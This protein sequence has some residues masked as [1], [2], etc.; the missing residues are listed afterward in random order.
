[1]SGAQVSFLVSPDNQLHPTSRTKLRFSQCIKNT[2]V[3]KRRNKNNY[4]RTKPKS[5]HHHLLLLNKA[6]KKPQFGNAKKYS[7][8]NSTNG[9][10]HSSNRTVEFPLL[11]TSRQILQS[12]QFMPNTKK[13]ELLL[14]PT[15]ILLTLR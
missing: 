11:M 5:N 13:F 12:K 1:M 8:F 7:T 3:S 6:T 2:I 10:P 9:D 4:L 15:K 14:L